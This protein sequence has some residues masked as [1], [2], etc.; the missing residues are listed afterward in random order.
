MFALFLTL[1]ILRLSFEKAC[2]FR[3]L[4]ICIHIEQSRQNASKLLHGNFLVLFTSIAGMTIFHPPAVNSG[5][6]A[7][8]ENFFLLKGEP[9]C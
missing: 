4:L 9:F 6:Q 5:Q 2:M 8:S 1:E 7:A 3:V